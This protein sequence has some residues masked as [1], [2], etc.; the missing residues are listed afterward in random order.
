[1]FRS[2]YETALCRATK[3][4]LESVLRRDELIVEPYAAKT[5]AFWSPLSLFRTPE[6]RVCVQPRYKIP[7]CPCR[8]E[9]CSCQAR[10]HGRGVTRHSRDGRLCFSVRSCSRP[11]GLV[12]RVP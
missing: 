1:M 4:I 8:V 7:C 2:S 12:G 3:L 6:G 9:A 10:P 11:E 5:C